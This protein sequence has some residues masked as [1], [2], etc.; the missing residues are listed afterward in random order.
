MTLMIK[1]KQC[2]RDVENKILMTQ[3]SEKE[4]ETEKLSIEL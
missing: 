4:N 3:D 2:E 1:I